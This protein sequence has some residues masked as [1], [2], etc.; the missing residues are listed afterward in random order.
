[1][2]SCSCLRFDL[3][4]V[5]VLQRRIFQSCLTN[6]LVKVSGIDAVSSWPECDDID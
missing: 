5:S 3:K 4:D 1:M 6:N 2:L